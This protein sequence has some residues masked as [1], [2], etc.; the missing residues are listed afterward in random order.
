MLRV[1]VEVEIWTAIPLRWT[2]YRMHCTRTPWWQVET[3]RIVPFMLFVFTVF[4]VQAPFVQLEA[5]INRI[6]YD[7]LMFK[8]R[9]LE[10][11]PLKGKWGPRKDL[12]KNRLDSSRWIYERLCTRSLCQSSWELDTSCFAAKA[13]FLISWISNTFTTIIILG[14]TTLMAE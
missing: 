9:H 14:V 8:I 5:L 10:I 7:K 1:V 3:W 11:C 12:V 2:P 13:F 6:N 4:N